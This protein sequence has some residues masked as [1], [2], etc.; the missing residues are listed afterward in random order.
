MP[1]DPVKVADQIRCGEDFELDLRAY[2][3]RRA[4]RPLKLE[5]IPMALLFHLIE[6]R[7]HLVMR[8]QIIERIWGK[9]VFLD[10]DSSINAAIRKI[11]QVLR[12]DPDS[13]ASCRPS[14]DADTGSSRRWSKPA[15]R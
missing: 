7:G 2:E 13:P 5:R 3:L 4:G 9:D 8:D 10:T 1:S 15:P 12:D 14:P 11:R 6:K